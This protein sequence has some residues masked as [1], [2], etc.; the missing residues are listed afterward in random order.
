MLGLLGK[1]L[2]IGILVSAPMGPVGMLCIQRTLSKGRWHGFVTGLGAVL[3][4]LIYAMVTGL[5]MGFVINFIEANQT[6]LQ[7]IGSLVLGFFGYYLLK[8]NPTKSLKKQKEGKLS[9]TQDFITGFLL[10]FSNIL[11]VLLFIGL[12]AHFG[13]ILPEYSVWLLLGGIASIGVGAVLW[14]FFITYLVSKVKKWFNVRGVW[15]LNRVVGIVIVVLAVIGML[16]AVFE[17]N[18][19]ISTNMKRLKVPYLAAL[20]ASDLPSAGLLMEGK[21]QR[22]YIDHVNWP[23]EYPY[24]PTVVF[25]IARSDSYLFIRYI[26]EGNS[27]KAVYDQDNSPVYQDSCVEFFMKKMGE[28]EYMN[29]EFNCI[30]T[31]DAAHR[32]SRDAKVSLSEGEYKA[33]RRYSSIEG[34]PFD[35]KKG[36]YS[37][38]LLVAIPFEV[39]G[40]DPANLPEKILG[41]F[42]KCAD[43]TD[44]PHYVSWNPID[45]PS[46]DFHR[47]EFFGEI[48]F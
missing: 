40:L 44:S 25:D 15:L 16:S 26:V 31:C 19:K 1:G 42:Y 47:P 24:K 22:E 30:G 18:F 27:L 39:M 43:N 32:T 45:T 6:P 41:N 14:W 4:D 11:I 10:T 46:P 29:F 34:K 23:E 36:V 21:A 8:T 20:N 28:N 7:L 17:F 48:F 37:W 35:E 5:G 38:E 13:F 3:S 12:F 33:I 9:Y 2:F